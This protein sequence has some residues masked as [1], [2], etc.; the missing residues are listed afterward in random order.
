MNS[1]KFLRYY[2]IISASLVAIIVGVNWYIDIYGL[3]RGKKNRNMYIN[4]RTSKYLFSLRYIPENFDGFIAGP[5]LSANLNPEAIPEFKI[6][7]ASI[8]GVNIT[9]LDYLIDN[10]VDRGHMKFAILCLGPYLTMN[11]GKK[12]A[13][14]DRKEYYGALGST[15]LLRTYLLYFVR[16]YNLAPYRYAQNIYN[17]VGWDNFELEME[18]LDA[19]DTIAAKVAR[20]D[21]DKTAIDSVALQE[22]GQTLVKLRQKHVK[23][24]AYFSPVPYQLY[25]LGK[26]DYHNYET[27]ISSLFTPDDILINL[28]A[29]QYKQTNADYHTF[30]DHGHL[31]G[32]GQA[33]VLH[34]LDS[35]LK[36]TFDR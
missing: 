36:A 11:H 2:I 3:F 4:E 7:N 17:T 29:D 19:K 14:I 26:S 30:I 33:F 1:K 21:I 32:N 18:G 25:Q 9:E 23:V 10:M 27:K 24:I 15:N 8:M 20:H 34:V 16:K 5:S 31:S 28:N 13:S 22:L 35:T 12:A 6:Y